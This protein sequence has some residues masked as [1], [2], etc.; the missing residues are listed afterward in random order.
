LNE[1]KDNYSSSMKE[2]Y[3]NLSAAEHDLQHRFKTLQFLHDR[4]IESAL[5]LGSVLNTTA[6]TGV[7]QALHTMR[8]DI[9]EQVLTSNLN[10]SN[11]QTELLYL[12]LKM[13][14]GIKL[15]KP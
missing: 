13:V 8:S 11:A 1:L 14:G 12:R 5:L 7:I 10:Q 15:R 6:L 3:L 9:E 4:I 2:K